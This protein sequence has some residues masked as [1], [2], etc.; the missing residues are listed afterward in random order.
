MNEYIRTSL[1]KSG[2][3]TIAVGDDP[4]GDFAYTVGFTELGHPEILISG[5]P[6]RICHQ[7]FW[8]LYK[9]IKAGKVYKSGEVDTDFANLPMAF[10]TLSPGAA[11]KFCCQAVYWYEDKGQTPT[12]L[13]LVAP[14][15]A[16]R[17]PWQ[18]GYDTQL[19]RWQRHLW[20]NLH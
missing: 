3:A 10:K 19:M 14:D 20:V 16:G 12:F 7:F 15:A 8:D 18:D 9:A 4:A 6:P 13:Q 1:A 5:L 17:F 11:E 2:F